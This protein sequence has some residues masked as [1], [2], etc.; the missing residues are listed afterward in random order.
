MLGRRSA[1]LG[2]FEAG[3]RYEDV[4]GKRTLYD[5]VAW[6]LMLQSDSNRFSN[7]LR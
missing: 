2:V 7:C 5:Y 3:T 6:T 4:V 1:R